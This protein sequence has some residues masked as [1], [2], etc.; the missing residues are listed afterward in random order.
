[1][2]ACPQMACYFTAVLATLK[3][4]NYHLVPNFNTGP[5]YLCDLGET[6]STPFLNQSTAT[7]EKVSQI[8][9]SWSFNGAVVRVSV[10]LGYDAA[11]LTLQRNILPCVFK[12][13]EVQE[14]CQKRKG[15]STGSSKKN[16][17]IIKTCHSK[18]VEHIE[19]I[20]VLK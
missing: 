4:L 8:C 6:D 1:M 20:Q 17:G 2:A 15:I 10:L 5:Q 18:T 19:M 3:P 9:E 11:C 7:A 16:A 12:G 14:E 13:L